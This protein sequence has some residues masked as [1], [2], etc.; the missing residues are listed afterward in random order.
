MWI[1]VEAIR[2]LSLLTVVLSLYY[3]SAPIGT[4]TIIAVP[5]SVGYADVEPSERLI[6]L[7]LLNPSAPAN[8]AA[9]AE[10]DDHPQVGH[11]DEAGNAEP[12]VVFRAAKGVRY[13]T[14]C[15]RLCDGFYYP[16]NFLTTKDRLV[17]D[18]KV[19]SNSCAAPARLFVN[20]VVGRRAQPMR[21]LQGNFYTNLKT[22]FAF[23]HG[24]T[25][26]YTCSKTKVA[27]Q[28]FDRFDPRGTIAPL[29]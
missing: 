29:Q 8:T 13:R 19:C 12:P 28:A 6:P 20:A 15:V 26:D 21:D 3:G 24:V 1:A 5:R 25:P 10:I 22:A 4:S 9:A 17:H 16:V 11:D 2:G 27:A 7:T 18:A 23:R 14:W